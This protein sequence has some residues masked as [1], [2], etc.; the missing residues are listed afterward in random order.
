MKDRTPF[1]LESAF[2]ANRPFLLNG[3]R[4]TY[5]DPVDKTGIEPRRLRQMWEHRL[6]EVSAASPA[7]KPPEKPPAK[8]VA[9]KAERPAPSPQKPAEEPPAPTGG[10][11]HVVYAQFG[12]WDV[13]DASGAVLLKG[14]S[15]DE[16]QSRLQQ[17]G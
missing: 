3:V 17:I 6:I 16:A 5:E 8:R 7:P 12:K 11:A 4:L 13:V 10:T 2:K 14:V 1:S 15:K 9:A